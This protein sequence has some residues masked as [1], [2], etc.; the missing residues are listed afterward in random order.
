V[1]NHHSSAH[2]RAS[3]GMT[4]ME[5]IRPPFVA[6][7]NQK[8]APVTS[9][10]RGVMWLSLGTGNL[11]TLVVDKVPLPVD[12]MQKNDVPL[13]TFVSCITNGQSL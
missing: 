2:N 8:Y 10:I 12:T 13:G 9:K 3:P 4:L 1:R 11:S 7:Y 6:Y 5:V